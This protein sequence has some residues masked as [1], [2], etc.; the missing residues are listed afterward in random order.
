MHIEK[1]KEWVGPEGVEEKVVGFQCFFVTQT[2]GGK[3]RTYHQV[4]KETPTPVAVYDTEEQA[5][6]KCID[7]MAITA[8][9]LIDPR[10]T[11]TELLGDKK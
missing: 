1:G 4:D 10:A 11:I 3:F 7:M 6:K 2:L 9:Y 5:K 8:S